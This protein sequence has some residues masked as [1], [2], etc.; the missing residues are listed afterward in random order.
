[1]ALAQSAAKAH[2]LAKGAFVG[3][4]L[5]TGSFVPALAPQGPRWLPQEQVD[6]EIAFRQWQVPL[7][8]QQ[9][10]DLAESLESDFACDI[11][12]SVHAGKGIQ[13][14]VLFLRVVS[15]RLKECV[16]GHRAEVRSAPAEPLEKTIELLVPRLL[17]HI[18]KEITPATV[19]LVEQRR[20]IHLIASDGFW[21]KGM[22]LLFVREGQGRLAVS[23]RGKLTRVRRSI[24]GLIVMEARS[25]GPDPA[26]RP[27]DRAVALVT[28]PPPFDRWH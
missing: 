2:S 20:T 1:M 5:V 15:A 25:E 21:K 19:K 28:P 26:V 10:A 16:W 27:S 17:D 22:S 24:G 3:V 12:V 14:A 4:F 23:G 6:R 7:K 8:T 13:T 9:L 18:P 11:L